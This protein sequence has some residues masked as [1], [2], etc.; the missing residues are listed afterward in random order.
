[1]DFPGE[2][3]NWDIAK[4]FLNSGFMT[5]LIG[6]LAG[7]SAGA[8]AAQKI[9]SRSK[10]QEE[11]LAQIRS[12]NVAIT[13][14]VG[15]CNVFLGLKRQHIKDLYENFQ[16]K[17]QEARDL[18]EKVEA[19]E[20]Q[21]PEPFEFKADF[22]TL[23]MPKV[24]NDVL[25]NQIYQKLSVSGRPLSLVATIDGALSSLSYAMETRNRLIEHFKNSAYPNE[26][27]GPLYFG[28]PFGEG[29]VNS[30]YADILEAINTYTDDLI[31]F[32]ELLAKDLRTHGELHLRTLSKKYKATGITVTSFDFS[33]PRDQGLMPNAEDYAD[34]LRGFR[35]NEDAMETEN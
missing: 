19:G 24:P 3:L 11:I 1:M 9:A 32:S 14:C 31:F 27:L 34:W 30:E 22:R 33:T 21:N 15:V 13:L 18:L 7:A 35:E 4:A 26:V 6:A 20:I 5:S 2:Y 29:H 17:R 10:D 23:Q 16:R 12:T 25:R 8:L 28:L